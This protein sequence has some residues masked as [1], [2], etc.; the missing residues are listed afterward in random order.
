MYLLNSSLTVHS[1]DVSNSKEQLLLLGKWNPPSELSLLLY[2]LTVF[3]DS[4]RPDNHNKTTTAFL[5]QKQPEI[6]EFGL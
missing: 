6:D 4:D 1:T 5:L 3:L 2:P